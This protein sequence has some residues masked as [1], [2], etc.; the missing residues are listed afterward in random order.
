MSLF[1]W[2]FSS[3]AT[4]KRCDDPFCP[5]CH[6][7]PKDSMFQPQ[8]VPGPVAAQPPYDPA[9]NVYPQVYGRQLD[10]TPASMG[11]DARIAAAVERL[12]TIDDHCLSLI[13]LGIRH[14]VF[15]THYQLELLALLA[16]VQADIHAAASD[17]IKLLQGG[18]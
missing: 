16:R 1:D 2:L 8:E 17:A 5:E 6:P 14:T 11:A 3:T 4:L 7:Y 18:N 13:A 15:P 10:A 9:R 12:R